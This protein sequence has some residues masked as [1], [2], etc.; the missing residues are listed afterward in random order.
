MGVVDEVDWCSVLRS[1]SGEGT[2]VVVWELYVS[3]GS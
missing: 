3:E 2:T 1:G